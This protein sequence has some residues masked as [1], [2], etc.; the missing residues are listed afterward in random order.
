M[1]TSTLKRIPFFTAMTTVE[2]KKVWKIAEVIELPEQTI[3]FS[4]NEECR[5]FY[6]LIS[7]SVKIFKLAPTGK[8]HVLHI[9]KDGGMF[10]EAAMFSGKTYPAFAKTIVRSSLLFFTK[11]G[12]LKLIRSDPDVSMKMLGA[13]ST[14]LR[15]LTADIEGISLKETPARLSQYLLNIVRQ[16]DS[17]IVTLTVKKTD[18]ALSLGIASETLSRTLKKLKD[19]HVIAIDGRQVHIL[20]IDL[21]YEIANGMKI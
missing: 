21:L 9:C 14:K 12:F 17:D 7:G 8:E 2:L 3:I 13:L 4:E 5:G 20:D 18:L 10:A 15:K 1:S 6:F 11:N 16:S 19:N